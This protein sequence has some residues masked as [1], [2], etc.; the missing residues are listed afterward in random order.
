MFT[1]ITDLDIAKFIGGQSYLAKWDMDLETTVEVHPQVDNLELFQQENLL[2]Y[3]VPKLEFTEQAVK[4]QIDQLEHEHT[5]FNCPDPDYNLKDD[6]WVADYGE[7]PTYVTFRKYWKP[8]IRGDVPLKPLLWKE[9]FKEDSKEWKMKF[10]ARYWAT[11]Y[12]I[13]NEEP[14]EFL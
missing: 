12:Q 9:C 1:H 10:D 6:T 8:R 13:F 14:P 11:R 7:D 5:I 2:Y 4:E 3:G